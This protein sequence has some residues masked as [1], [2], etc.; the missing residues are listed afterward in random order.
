MRQFRRIHCLFLVGNQGDRLHRGEAEPVARGGG[1]AGD[2]LYGGIEFRDMRHA[3][4]VPPPFHGPPSAVPDTARVGWWTMEWWWDQPGVPPTAI[5]LSMPNCTN[6]LRLAT[7]SPPPMI[8]I[9]T[10]GPAA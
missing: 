3:R 2:F 8:L 1:A 7:W 6:C 5:C 4:L 9:S 10:C